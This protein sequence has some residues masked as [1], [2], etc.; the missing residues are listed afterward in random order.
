M[1]SALKNLRH[2]DSIVILPA[3]KG[4]VTVLMNKDDYKEKMQEVLQEGEYRKVAA[5]PTTIVE[6]SVNDELRHLFQSGEI[7]KIVY[8]QLRIPPT[9]SH[10]SYMVYRR[11][12]KRIHP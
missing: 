11:F 8:D 5:D 3:D 6:K 2:N 1:R 4:N 9:V 12:T 7:N 10:H